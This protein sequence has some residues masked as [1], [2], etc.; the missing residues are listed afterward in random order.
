MAVAVA[1]IGLFARECLGVRQEPWRTT[2]KAQVEKREAP[3]L[4]YG[5]ATQVGAMAVKLARLPGVRPLL[6]VA[7]RGKTFVEGLL[8]KDAG[9]VFVD[10]REGDDAVVQ[11]LGGALDGRTCTYAF[12]AVSTGSSYANLARVLAPA[13]RLTMVLPGKLD[14]GGLEEIEVSYAMAGSLWKRLQ[15]RAEGRAP[16][17]HVANLGILEDGSI[18]AQGMSLYVAELLAQG[19]LQG[20]PYEV[21][22]GGLGGLEDAL[23]RLKAGQNSAVKYVVRVGETANLG[24][25]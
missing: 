21:L 4:I 3:L 20:H 14:E 10:Y 9:D 11:A 24:E 2:H 22:P 13:G 16:S 8:D 18:F 25:S 1:S 6:C 19:R 5:A 17:K 15:P 7:G 23:N 12:D